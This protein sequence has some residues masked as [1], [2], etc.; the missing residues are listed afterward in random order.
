MN[1][2][3]SLKGLVL[4][5]SEL[6]GCLY[7]LDCLEGRFSASGL[8]AYGI[9][10]NPER[11]AHYHCTRLSL[12]YAACT[13]A[14]VGAGLRQNCQSKTTNPIATTLSTTPLSKLACA[15]SAPADQSPPIVMVPWAAW[16]TSVMST[17]PP[18]RLNN[19]VYQNVTASDPRRKPTMIDGCKPPS[20]RKRRGTCQPVT[21]TPR[22]RV[23]T[24]GERP[25]PCSPGRA[26][27]RQPGSSPSAPSPG[28]TR[29]TAKNRRMALTEPK[30]SEGVLAPSATLSTAVIRRT[31]SGS[32]MATTYQYHLTR[33]R[34]TREPSSRSPAQPWVRGMTMRAASN[35]EPAMKVQKGMHPH[36]I[37]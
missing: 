5:Y 7:S 15:K 25:D 28:L 24:S 10:G 33:Q 31:V 8:P 23:D 4:R 18:V 19:H 32:P 6:G 21:S 2:G 26:K 36:P 20:S 14:G 22:M 11:P 16:D 13:V 3:A 12:S 37:A 9:L 29:R 35:G 27:P 17:L 34:I 30:A 1:P